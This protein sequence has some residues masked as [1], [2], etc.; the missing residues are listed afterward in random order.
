MTDDTPRWPHQVQ[1]VAD[2]HAAFASGFDDVCLVTPTGGGKSLMATDL[3]RDFYE[4][5]D[6]SVLYTN[7]RLLVTQAGKAFSAAGI[8]YGVRA[9]GHAA[10]IQKAVQI[11]SLLTEESR[12]FKRE[13]WELHNCKLAIIDE[14]H[15]VGRSPIAM[16]IIKTHLEAGVKVCRITATPVDLIGCQKLIVAGTNSSLRACG[17]HVPCHTFGPDEPDMRHVKK[18]AVGEFS[19]NDVTKKIMVQSIF[20][21]V[22]D[23]LLKLNYEMRPTILFAPG[24]KESRWFVEQFNR[25][26]ISAAHIEAETPDSEREDIINGSREGKIK[27]ICNRF[28]MR[29]GV[30]LPWLAHCVFA[31]VFG[32]LSNYLQAGGRLLR[33]YPGLQHV[34]LQDHGGNFHRFGSLNQDRTWELGDTDV[35]IEKK[36]KAA[37]N[38]GKGEPEPI[39][40]PKCRAVRKKGPKCWKCGHEHKRTLRLV[41]QVNGTLKPQTGNVH[42]PKKKSN[43]SQEQKQWDSVL[44]ACANAKQPKTYQQALALYK[45]KH[46][47]FPPF[48]LENMVPSD[49]GAKKDYIKDL[50]PKL[51]RY[52]KGAA[53]A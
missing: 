27:I 43:K 30:D 42:K 19:Y 31:T 53:N 5:G 26:G 41:V 36:K 25:R 50:F 35:E 51:V 15:G 9:S 38:E 46:G 18:N 6:G 39:I 21:R 8:D 22:Y 33:S 40:C 23:N 1:G 47:D 14:A 12:V 34:T 45:H 13:Q 37:I 28:V 32:A 3:V 16:K 11:S 4:G 49:S 48:G 2:V 24:V 7:R 20:G 52:K 44:Y 10:E 17:A 29:E